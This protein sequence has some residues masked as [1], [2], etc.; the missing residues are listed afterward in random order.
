ML[1]WGQSEAQEKVILPPPQEGSGSLTGSISQRKELPFFPLPLSYPAVR[2]AFC[3]VNSQARAAL[4]LHSTLKTS[5]TLS[6]KL[7]TTITNGGK[8]SFERNFTYL[9][10]G[11]VLPKLNP[12]AKKKTRDG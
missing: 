8:K 6:V 11:S 5:T 10:V 2:F 7:A 9:R 1:A 3:C 4:S 12:I